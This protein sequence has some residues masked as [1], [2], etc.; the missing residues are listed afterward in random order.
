MS[1]TSPAP[2]RTSST[3][4]ITRLVESKGATVPYLPASTIE[5]AVA[6]F[7]S[8]L[9]LGAVRTLSDFQGTAASGLEGRTKPWQGILCKRGPECLVAGFAHLPVT[10]TIE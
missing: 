9:R 4:A 10:E 7:K 5:T 8:N 1:R 3:P 6:T 2:R